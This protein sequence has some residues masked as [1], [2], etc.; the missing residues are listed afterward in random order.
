[1]LSIG[2]WVF[3]KPLVVFFAPQ[4]HNPQA[5]G[6]NCPAQLKRLPVLEQGLLK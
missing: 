2:S 6:A 1:M 5:L 4:L 3:F